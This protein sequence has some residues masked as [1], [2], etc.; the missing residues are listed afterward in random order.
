LDRWLSQRCQLPLSDQTT[1]EAK[2]KQLEEV[3]QQL[4]HSGRFGRLT[5]RL[6][7]RLAPASS[8]PEK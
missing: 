3:K 5:L 2:T 8:D 1:A 7:E 6:I 4:A